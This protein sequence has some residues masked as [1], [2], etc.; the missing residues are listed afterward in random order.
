[1]LVLVGW[2]LRELVI[3]SP[4]LYARVYYVDMVCPVP[5]EKGE[6]QTK[7]VERDEKWAARFRKDKVFFHTY[8]NYAAPIGNWQ[9]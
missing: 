6:T 5:A 8:S 9:G 1:M 2:Q 4:T 7:D 3:T